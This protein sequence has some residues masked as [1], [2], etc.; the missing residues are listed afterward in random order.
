MLKQQEISVQIAKNYWYEPTI[1][2]EPTI[3]LL[4]FKIGEISF[5]VSIDKIHQ[6]VTSTQ[7][8]PIPNTELLDL[9]HRLL[10][11]SCPDSAYSIVL[12]SRNN[13]LDQI[14][15]DIVPT[16]ISIRID[17]IRQIPND[18]RTT[19]IR[20]LSSHVANIGDVT[21]PEDLLFIL[22]QV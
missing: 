22:T 20:E 14:V 6:I 12:N 3:E 21:S 13:R 5:G 2:V 8:T 19:T 16:L 1:R 9:H 15:V 17:R 18:H 11:I 4:K 10:G 7:F